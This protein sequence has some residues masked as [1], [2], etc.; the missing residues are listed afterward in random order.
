MV[1]VTIDEDDAIHGL[2]QVVIEQHGPDTIY[3]IPQVGRCVYV[4]RGACSCLIAH[5]LVYLGVPVGALQP[6]NDTEI[7]DVTLAGVSISDNARRVFAAAQSAQ[8][9]GETWGQALADAETVYAKLT[10]GASS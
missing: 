5:V 9:I 4:E 2:R 7:T 6:W 1:A 3:R 8:D 10:A